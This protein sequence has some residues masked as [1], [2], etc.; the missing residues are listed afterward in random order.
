MQETWVR[1]LVRED[2]ME[3]EVATHS[4]ILAWKIPWME[5]PG[6]LQSMGLQWVGHD[7]ATTTFSMWTLGFGFFSLNIVLWGFIQV[8][9]CIKSLF[10]FTAEWYSMM[11]V[12]HGFFSHLS[13]ERH[14]SYFQFG[15]IMNKTYLNIHI[16]SLCEYIFSFLLGSYLWLKL[17]SCKISLWLTLEE[18]M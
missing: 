1:S 8:V 13:S 15:A 7:W 17:L 4:S 11:W 14:S 18:T 9:E 6:R 3:K 10:L 5:K 2:P 16:K 12:F